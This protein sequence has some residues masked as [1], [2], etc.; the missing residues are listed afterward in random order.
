MKTKKILPVLL[1]FF[2][3]LALIQSVA[4]EELVVV[5]FYYSASCS[6][7]DAYK[8]TIR[9][10]EDEQNYTE[11][12]EVNWR[13]VGSNSTNR[14]EWQD[15]GF[16]G[17]PSV[18]VYIKSANISNATK[19]PK[20]FLNFKNVSDAIDRYLAGIEA[21]QTYDE[22]NIDIPFIGTVNTSSL[23]LPVLTIVLGVVDSFNVC[24]IFILFIL[25]S[26]LVHAQSRKRMLLIGGI[27]VFFSGLFYLLFMFVLQYIFSSF[28][29]V[30]ISIIIG[31]VALMVGII[32]IKDFFFFKKGLTIGIP[33]V[34][35]PGI[36]KQMRNLVKNPSVFVAIYGTIVLAITV[37]LFE[38][39]CSWVLPAIFIER[40]ETTT[41]LS[42]FDKTSY[43]I[44][45][46][47]VYVIPLVIIVILFTLSLGKK[48]LTEWQ[49]QKLKLFSGIMV[50]SFGILFLFDYKS[51]ENVVT[52]IL[53]LLFSVFI[54][55][56]LSHIW[57]KYAEK[58]EKYESLFNKKTEEK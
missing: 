36:Y 9:Q 17:Y 25:L 57:K 51:V 38:L 34:K 40:L 30:I 52:P 28:E 47:I 48:T 12:V 43:I 24:S 49:G 6:S 50:S 37:N 26:L 21:N 29:M 22:T 27:F 33:E 42:S 44:A 35:K 11:K 20:S 54:T 56:I 5:N 1:L 8:P 2:V 16:Y 53:I 10:I 41:S 31:S 3:F 58:Q 18:A 15:L 14:K 23:S 4:A 32:N 55:V 19:I 46:N 39:V 45:Y 7:C 13:E